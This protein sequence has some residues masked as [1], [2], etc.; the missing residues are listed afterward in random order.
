[1]TVDYT[2]LTTGVTAQITAALP[3]AMIICSALLGITI[4][5]KIYRRFAK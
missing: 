4:G 5:L 3:Q 1:M 2:A